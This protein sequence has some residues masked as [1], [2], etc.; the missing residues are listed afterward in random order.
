MKSVWVPDFSRAR[1][2]VFGDVMLDEYVMGS[3][4]RISPEAPIPVF[5]RSSERYIPG[6]ASNVAA[7][8]AALGAQ[9]TLCGVVGIDTYADLLRAALTTHSPAVTFH[10][11]VDASRGTTVKTRFIASGHHLLRVDKETTAHI[12]SDTSQAI[13]EALESEIA[14]T[15]VVI[16]SDYAKGVIVEA[17]FQTLIERARE[18]GKI[19]FVDPKRRNFDFYHGADYL[20]PNRKE[21]HEAT[22]LPINDDAAIE[23]ASQVASSVSSSSILVTRSEEG[24]TLFRTGSPAIHIRATAREVFDVSGAGDTVIATFASAIAAGQP[25]AE[26]AALANIAAGVSVGKEG[27]ATV[28][29][30]E[31]R[32]A[33]EAY[34]KPLSR[35]RD[36]LIS[37]EEASVQRRI[38]AAEGL[39]VGFTNGCFDILHRGHVQLLDEV[40]L[41]CDRLIVGINSDKSVRLLKG[42]TRPINRA[43]DRA[44]VLLSLRAVAA[45]VIFEEETPAELIRALS[46]DLL[47]KG[48]DYQK[49]EIVGADF[50][51]GN[52]GEVM[53]VD[54]VKG[55]STT[56]II[57]SAGAMALRR[58]AE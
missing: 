21:L 45:V 24:M 5:Q 47:A 39:S 41:R 36:G 44:R 8:V 55:F 22:G 10:A 57:D 7:N 2:L 13:V 12:S 6:G 40:A 25:P 33:V 30:A 23:L 37:R 54:I 18:A 35:T 51:E 31:L 19:V 42:S 58:P 26:A 9:V 53:I 38:W 34:H 14:K 56:T 29:L 50:V 11:I 46:P 48:G 1:V 27:A 32:Q 20:T 15:D 16:V 28:G 43:E 4:Q 17:T 3:V 52:G 49:H